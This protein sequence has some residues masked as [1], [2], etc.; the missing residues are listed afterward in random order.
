MTKRRTT[1]HDVGRLA[2]VSPT[3]VSF[4]LNGTG[5]ISEATRN[6]VLAAV[7]ELGYVPD[8]RARSLKNRRI[9][10]LAL[11]FTY[12]EESMTSSR[13]FRDITASI[14]ATTSKQ[15]YRVMVALMSRSRSFQ[16]YVNKIKQDGTAG[17]LIMAGPSPE[18]VD[19]LAATLDGF[20]GL[21]LSAASSDPA[22]SFIDVDNREGMF[23][24][25]R[26]L[27]QLGHKRI[28]YV[29]PPTTDSHVAQRLHGYR[30][31][32][33]ANGLFE[34]LHIC[35]LSLDGE[36]TLPLSALLEIHT[37][38]IVAFDDFRALQVHNFLVRNG[39]QVPEDIALIGFD[40][41]EFGL[42]MSPPLTTVAQPFSEMGRLAAEKLIERINNPSLP[43]AQVTL[44]LRLVI[45]E[46]CG[47]SQGKGLI[48]SSSQP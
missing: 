26:H 4:V 6:K 5:H 45:R 43:S 32:M 38:A 25:V 7:D 48:R 44:P 47:A 18:E 28:A 20:P 21:V 9:E 36:D 13:Y 34:Y 35:V 3:T 31:A 19:I 29:T 40:D 37:T 15:G 46:S 16:E 33:I 24:A 27:V 2:Q 11:L 30:E 17:G 1:I 41:E 14:C 8:A 23:Q 22:L 39:L 42:H 12:T 10:V